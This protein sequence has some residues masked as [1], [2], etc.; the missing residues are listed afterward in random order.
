MKPKT[1]MIRFVGGKH[2]GVMLEIM[3]DQYNIVLPVYSSRIARFIDP[4][5]KV[6][7]PQPEYSSYRRA[8]I[9][10]N[11]E[12]FDVMI[13]PA[14]TGDQLIRRLILGYNGSGAG[15]ES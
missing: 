6:V 12:E 13:P 5:E 4:A 15:Q 9:R 1:E 14:M 11:T 2:D 7:E 10:G 3:T 8:T